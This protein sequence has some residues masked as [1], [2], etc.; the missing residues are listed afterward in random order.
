MGVSSFERRLVSVDLRVS[1]C[2]YNSE[3]GTGHSAFLTRHQNSKFELR[4]TI[5]TTITA[6]LTTKTVSARLSQQSTL[7]S[8]EIKNQKSKLSWSPPGG[9]APFLL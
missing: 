1:N 7:F 8:S 5:T 4:S 3:P 9:Q 2:E 6:S